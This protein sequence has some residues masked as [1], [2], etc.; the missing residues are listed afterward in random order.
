[1]RR[2]IQIVHAYNF[3]GNV[4]AI[5]PARIVAPVVIASIRDC[6]PYLTPMQKRVQ[7]YV[8]QFADRILVNAD[9]VKDWLINDGYD[10]S[11]ITNIP[12]GVD[13]TRFD[14]A[15][16]PERLRREFGLAERT[17]LVAVVS[18]L[19]RL[20]GLEHFLEAAA[21]IKT[22][23]P[24]A[25]FLVVGETSP[26]DRAYLDELKQHAERLGVADR[27][28]FAGLRT[29]VPGLLA[30]VNVSVMPS[31]NE[32]LSNVLLE[33]MAAGAPTVAT[34]VGGTP[35]AL[36]DGITGLLVPPGDTPA[37]TDAIVRMLGDPSMAAHMGRAARQRIADTFSVTRMVRA[38]EDIYLELLDRKQPKRLAAAAC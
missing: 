14:A 18:R 16:E 37:L 11:K 38:T 22:R 12:N 32:A 35:E 3:Y 21:A 10:P 30:S 23:V 4:F 26:M 24:Q 8:C 29:D 34:R 5:P 13:L 25:R 15:P 27:V 6:A 9:A 2:D 1:V 33:S 36:V 31:L 28:I 20:K 19:T 17:P 7:R